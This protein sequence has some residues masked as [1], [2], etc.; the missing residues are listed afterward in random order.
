ML[1]AMLECGCLETENPS[2]ILEL[3]PRDHFLFLKLISDLQGF[4]IDCEKDLKEAVY[5]HFS[6]KTSDLFFNGFEQLIDRCENRF[7]V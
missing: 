1:A 3:A 5:T 4:K 2:Y 7:E 6:D